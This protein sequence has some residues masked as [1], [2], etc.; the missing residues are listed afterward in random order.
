MLTLPKDKC[1]LVP[2]ST[3]CKNKERKKNSTESFKQDSAVP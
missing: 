1:H 3:Y 2:S